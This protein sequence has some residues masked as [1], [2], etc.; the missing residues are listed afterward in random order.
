MFVFSILLEGPGFGVR[1]V[2]LMN[3]TEKRVRVFDVCLV[4]G[5]PGLE[6]I[7]ITCN[8]KIAEIGRYAGGF[9]GQVIQAHYEGVSLFKSNT[10]SIQKVSE[11]LD[12]RQAPTRVLFQLTY[13]SYGSPFVFP[14][15]FRLE[16][17]RYR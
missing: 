9:N 3:D 11:I 16:I 10:L 5:P 13:P 8:V 1:P 15:M 7:P 4:D 17:M 14:F 6:E 12:F 2:T